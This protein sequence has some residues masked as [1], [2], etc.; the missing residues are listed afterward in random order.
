M[1]GGI[2]GSVGVGVGVEVGSGVGVIF[3]NDV[4][5]RMLDMVNKLGVV[6]EEGGFLEN[7]QKL[8][9]A[10]TTS[11]SAKRMYFVILVSYQMKNDLCDI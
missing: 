5:G 8:T 10:S 11:R 4:R 3:G 9:I 1:V 7:I 2:G 6:R